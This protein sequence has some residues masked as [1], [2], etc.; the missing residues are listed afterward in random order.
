MSME[1]QAAV[2]EDEGGEFELQTLELDE[3]QGDELLVRVVGAGVCHTDLSV[4]DQYYPT[5]L[6]GVLGHEGSGVVEEVGDEVT[7]V[8]P[9]DHVVMS[10]DYDGTCSNCNDGDVA[11]CEDFFAYNFAG[12]RP[13]DQ[14]SPLSRDGGVVSG[15]FFGQ[16]SF[17]TH[18]IATER[19]VVVVPDDA[20]LELLGPLGCGIQTGAGAVINSL[21][22]QAGSSIV[23]MGAGSVGLSGLLGANLK[24]CGEKVVVD[25]RSNRLDKAEELGATKTI[26]PQAV[27]DTEEAIQEYLGGGADYSLEATGE[28]SVLRQA[29]DMLRQGGACGVVG[30]PPLGTE[31]SLDINT[32]LFGRTVRGII[33]GDSHPKEFIPDL[34]DLYQDGRFPFDEFVTYYDLDEIGEAVEAVEEGHSIKPILRVSEP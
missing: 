2:V 26:N 28:P 32:V 18:A 15:R 7:G 20:P 13:G 29:V 12:R 24:G 21:D 23:I 3:P 10:F 8:E 1:I 19:N 22:P 9:G 4:R 17:G 33:E 16:S 31:V 34:V 30:A 14:S 11:Y 5:P 6:P 25:L 27:E